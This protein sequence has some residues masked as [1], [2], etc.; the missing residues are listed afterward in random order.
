MIKVWGYSECDDTGRERVYCR[1]VGEMHLS[2]FIR[3]ILNGHTRGT[4]WIRDRATET[5]N[6]YEIELAKSHPN[7]VVVYGDYLKG[8]HKI[9][10]VL[11]SI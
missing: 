6:G 10:K 8:E 4:T 1:Y 11:D 7:K 5:G 2:E 3:T 9:R